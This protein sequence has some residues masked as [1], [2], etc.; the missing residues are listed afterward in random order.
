MANVRVYFATNRNYLAANKLEIFGPTFNADGVAALRFG[1]ADF[2]DGAR[3]TAVEVYPEEA[4]ENGFVVKGSDRFLKTLHG[5]MANG[6]TDTLV[7]IHGFNVTF[8]GALS[9][10]AELAREVT[11]DGHP[12]NVVVFSWPSDGTAVPLMSYYSDRE[13]ARASGPAIARAFLKLRDFVS[14]LKFEDY[15]Q[16]RLHLLAHSMGCYALRQG[17]QAA[18]AKDPR[19]LTRLFDQILLAAPD[20]D[21]D[22]FERDDKLKPLPGL[23]RQVTVYHNPHDRALLV[24]DTTKTNPDRLGSDGPRLIDMLPKKVV[25]VDCQVVAKGADSLVEHT[26]YIHSRAVSRDIAAVMGGAA[27]EAIG[28]R[29]YIP[30]RRA[31]RIMAE[32]PA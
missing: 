1:H 15:C 29:D 19:S 23:G 10:A 11:V 9:A 8:M 6:A 4:T 26:Y 32:L 31:W 16:R 21:D 27:P 25:V 14:G 20:E 7:F 2:E 13:D 18:L 5:A 30:T 24:S 3:P 17:L 22:A 28:N 12:L